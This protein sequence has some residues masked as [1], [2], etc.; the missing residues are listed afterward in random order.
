[1]EARPRDWYGKSLQQAT[2]LGLEA[3]FE[4]LNLALGTS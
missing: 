3:I 4:Q 2:P 1:M